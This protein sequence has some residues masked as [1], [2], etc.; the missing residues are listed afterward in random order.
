MPF[1]KAE[2]LQRMN[3]CSSRMFIIAC[4]CNACE[5]MYTCSGS[6]GHAL[7]PSRSNSQIFENYFAYST[8]R[9]YWESKYSIHS[10]ENKYILSR[11]LMVLHFGNRFISLCSYRGY[12]I[13]LL[14]GNVKI[15]FIISMCC[16]TMCSYSLSADQS[17]SHQT[18]SKIEKLEL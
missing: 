2:H 5:Q 11:G 3:L 13:D 7:M 1:I 14:L 12:V 16:K 4:W 8:L 18:M 10:N 9:T 6:G 15:L 17:R